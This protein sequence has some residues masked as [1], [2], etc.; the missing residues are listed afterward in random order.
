MTLEQIEGNLA[1]MAELA[2]ANHIRVVLC[3][4]LPA[5]DFPG[6]PGMTPAPKVD[7]AEC[8]DQGLRGGKGPRLCGL[9]HGDE[10]RARRAAGELSKDGVH[11][12]PAGYAI[13]APLVEA[14]IQKALEIN[15]D[16]GFRDQ[17]SEI[18]RGAPTISAWLISGFIAKPPQSPYNRR[19]AGKVCPKRCPRKRFIPIM[20]RCVKCACGNNFETRSTH[21]GDIHVEICS[22]CH[23]FFTGK[24][25]LVDTA[26]RVERF[27]RKYAKSDAAWRRL[28]SQVTAPAPDDTIG[29]PPRRRPNF[30]REECG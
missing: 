1:S 27:R 8:V 3:S 9:P 10:G 24:Q 23:P 12:L 22:N 21:K 4:V 18:G 11:P 19:I 5:F 13:M 16:S 7:G 28:R 20:P 2:T 17:G 14:G 15:R 6:G 25:R 30:V 26:G 29:P